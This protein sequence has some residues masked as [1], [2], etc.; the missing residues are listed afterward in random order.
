[1]MAFMIFRRRIVPFLIVSSVA[2]TACGGSEAA[3]TAPTSSTTTV[4]A[5]SGPAATEPAPVETEPAPVETAPAPVVTEPAPV[6]TEPA[7]VATE[8]APATTSPDDGADGSCLIGDWVIT[9]AEMNGYYDV[10]TGG[11]GE[12]G[13]PVE[14]DIV[15]QTLLTFTETGYVY[16]AD[17][18]L[19]L[20]VAGTSGTGVSTGTVSGTWET[21]EGRLVTSLGE[22]NLNVIIDVGGRTVDGS[23]IAGGFLASSPINDAPFDCAGPTLGFQADST[24]AVRHD[25]TLTPA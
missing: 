11:F 12:G 7:P 17:F 9:Q 14:I 10:V 4:L 5:A 18:D 16:T 2:L 22:S 25:V 1:M 8:P 3:T 23:D 24:G 6:A 20:A 21:D 15:G 19:T 13:P